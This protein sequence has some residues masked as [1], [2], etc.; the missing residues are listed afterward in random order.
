MRTQDIIIGELYRHRTSKHLTIGYARAIKILKPLPKY[1]QKYAGYTEEEGNIKSV[2][3]KCEWMHSK[4]DNIGYI[5][6]FRPCDL[7]KEDI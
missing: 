7:V 2:V 6:Y 1:K 3:V 4:N 5:K